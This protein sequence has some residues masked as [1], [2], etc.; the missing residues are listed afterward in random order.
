MNMNH[1]IHE[2]GPNGFIYLLLSTHVSWVCIPVFLRW[3]HVLLDYLAEFC[4][5]ID[6][7]HWSSVCFTYMIENLVFAALM[8][9]LQFLMKANPWKLFSGRGPVSRTCSFHVSWRFTPLCCRASL[10]GFS[11]FTSDPAYNSNSRPKGRWW[12]DS[13]LRWSHY[14]LRRS[15]VLLQNWISLW[16]KRRFRMSQLISGSRSTVYFSVAQIRCVCF[17][18]WSS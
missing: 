17:L 14:R 1:P 16:Y 6:I 12:Y 7:V 2:S 11:V 5:M 8:K 4:N 9:H 15:T 13:S 18:R 3:K 10:N